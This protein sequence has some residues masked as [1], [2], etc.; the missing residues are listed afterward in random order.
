MSDVFAIA[1]R[2]VIIRLILKNYPSEDQKR[3]ETFPKIQCILLR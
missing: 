1:E 2:R 3:V